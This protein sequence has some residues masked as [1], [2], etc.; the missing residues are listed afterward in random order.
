MLND[1][2]RFPWAQR[3]TAVATRLAMVMVC[4]AARLLPAAQETRYA[5]EFC[6]ELCDLAEAGASRWKQLLY[7]TRQ[8]QQ[9]PGLRAGL[10]SAPRWNRASP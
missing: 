2:R 3:A 5:E 6:A 10:R 7:A 8:I 1:A 9:I 4:M